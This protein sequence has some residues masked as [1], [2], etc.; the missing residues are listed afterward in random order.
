MTPQWGE[1]APVLR[2]QVTGL[3]LGLFLLFFCCSERFGGFWASSSLFSGF[4]GLLLGSLGRAETCKK[5]WLKICRAKTAQNGRF[6]GVKPRFR[7][8]SFFRL[9]REPRRWTFSLFVCGPKHFRV[10]RASSS[11]FCK[12]CRSKMALIERFRGIKPCFRHRSLFRLVREPRQWSF[13]SFFFFA[14]LSIL[15]ASGPRRRD[16][17]AFF[18]ASLVQP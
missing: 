10:V 3:W 13:L 14:V 9:I 11:L 1:G 4:L 17:L 12:V 2:L 5:K 16:F 18:W 7:H 8:K 15:G 6:R